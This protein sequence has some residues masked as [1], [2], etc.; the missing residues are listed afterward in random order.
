MGQVISYGEEED[1]DTVKIVRA[2]PEFIAPGYKNFEQYL[3][4]ALFMDQRSRMVNLTAIGANALIKFTINKEG[5][6]TNISVDCTDM[7]LNFPLQ[8]AI[9]S[10]PKW[11]PGIK[12]DRPVNTRMEF[13]FNI[14]R[15]EAGQ[16]VVIPERMPPALDKNNWPLKLGIISAAVAGMIFAWIRF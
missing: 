9:D 1:T 8:Q 2:A 7:N 3:E 14:T 13:Y 15:V 4:E 10:M 5:K 12:Y 16:F 11:K 6:A